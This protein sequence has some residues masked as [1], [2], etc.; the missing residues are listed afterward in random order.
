MLTE[1]VVPDFFWRFTVGHIE[2]EM[3]LN[4]KEEKGLFHTVKLF[5]FGGVNYLKDLE[6]NTYYQVLICS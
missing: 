6:E 1:E 4:L 5:L 2:D 3:P